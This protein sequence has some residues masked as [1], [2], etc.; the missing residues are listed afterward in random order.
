MFIS[1]TGHKFHIVDPSPWPFLISLGAGIQLPI[2]AVMYM[3]G[4]IDGF[5]I[6][7][8]GILMSLWWY[9]IIIEGTYQNMHTTVVQKGLRL[10]FLLFIVSE[11]M[12]FASFFWAFFH[13]ALAPT[14]EIMSIWVPSRLQ[15]FL[16]KPYKIPLL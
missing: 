8:L 9:D 2:G 10:G 6:I 3:H 16:F 15:L 4:E 1:S 5:S 7:L 13:S 14:I 12:F 11:V